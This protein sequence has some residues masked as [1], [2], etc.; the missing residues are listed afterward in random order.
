MAEGGQMSRWGMLDL[1]P[2]EKTVRRGASCLQLRHTRAVDSDQRQREFRDGALSATV[3]CCFE[4]TAFSGQAWACRFLDVSHTHASLS[5]LAAAW[6]RTHTMHTCISLYFRLQP[7]IYHT[8]TC[9]HTFPLTFGCSLGSG[10]CLPWPCCPC[11]PICSPS[12]PLPPILPPP[13]RPASRG[14]AVRGGPAAEAGVV[15]EEEG[16]GEQGTPSS[17]QGH[18]TPAAWAWV[19]WGVWLRDPRLK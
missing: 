19:T 1:N 2:T 18:L 7:R 3:F 6:N 15:A 10:L 13:I 17:R 8:H 5:S 9:I 14:R 12:N 16:A 4:H 11:P